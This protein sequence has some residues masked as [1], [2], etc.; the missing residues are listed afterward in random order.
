MCHHQLQIPMMQF[1]LFGYLTPTCI[2]YTQLLISC[3]LYWV[4]RR[5]IKQ[6]ALL[7]FVIMI[8]LNL[9]SIL[10]TSWILFS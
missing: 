9:N 6:F 10:K 4:F 3:V 7:R 8:A 5:L 2:C 1:L